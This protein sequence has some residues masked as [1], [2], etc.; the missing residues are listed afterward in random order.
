MM[1]PAFS[2]NNIF[3]F[4]YLAVCVD[5]RILSAFEKFFSAVR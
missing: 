4:G 3:I 2:F 1:L 5:I